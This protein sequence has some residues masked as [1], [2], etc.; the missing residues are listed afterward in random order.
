MIMLIENID[1]V[2]RKINRDVMYIAFA[3]SK[4]DERVFAKTREFI[5]AELTK[6]KINH[7][8]CFPFIKNSVR[9][10]GIPSA[11][12]IDLPYEPDSKNVR[13]LD[14]LLENKDG[15]PS[16]D[17]VLFALLKLENAQIN[18]NQDSSN[19]WENL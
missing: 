15:T 17:G 13:F 18:A 12:Y 5:L 14:S 1:A 10:G 6:A 3:E 7:W 9:L 11:L 19:F 2:A 16:Y 4:W 8:Y